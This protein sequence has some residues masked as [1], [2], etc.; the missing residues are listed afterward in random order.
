MSLQISE[1]H[2]RAFLNKPLNLDGEWLDGRCGRRE[3]APAGWMN[4]ATFSVPRGF[5][6][7]KPSH[8]ADTVNLRTVWAYLALAFK[9]R[10]RDLRPDDASQMR[11]D[12]IDRGVSNDGCERRFVRGSA[13]AVSVS[14]SRH[15]RRCFKT[16]H[17]SFRFLEGYISILSDSE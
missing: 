6:C 7:R 10:D 15:H 9:S 5:T 4:L 3:C 8:H 11:G 17:V 12:E 13:R 2:F 1:D 14:N 16:I